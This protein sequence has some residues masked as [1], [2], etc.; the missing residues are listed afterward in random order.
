[1]STAALVM[2]WVRHA[3]CTAPSCRRQVLQSIM[4]HDLE[5]RCRYRIR[6]KCGDR[7]DG[8]RPDCRRSTRVA[9][10][11]LWRRDRKRYGWNRG[12]RQCAG[13]WLQPDDLAAASQH[14]RRHR[15]QCRGRFRINKPDLSAQLAQQERVTGRRGYGWSWAPVRSLG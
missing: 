12:R 6:A 5:I 14:R 10:R 9:D 7:L 13:W 8:R 4:P 2:S 11:H 1:M 3:T 15:S